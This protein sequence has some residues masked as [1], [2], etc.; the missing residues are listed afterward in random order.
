MYLLGFATE[1]RQTP[2][3]RDPTYLPHDLS[4]SP[5][6]E[7][8]TPGLTDN[9]S[10]YH[11]RSLPPLTPHLQPGAIT[12]S[13]RCHPTSQP[14]AMEAGF[15]WDSSRSTGVARNLFVQ[16]TAPSS[17]NPFASVGRRGSDGFDDLDLNSHAL[18]LNTNVSFTYLLG[19]S[20]M[21]HVLQDDVVHDVGGRGGMERGAAPVQGGGRGGRAPGRPP[22][23]S[24]VMPYRAPR[25]MVN[26]HN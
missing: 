2:P 19:S 12:L 20:P 24:S 14:T 18:D 3:G 4:R 11:R 1:S 16:H 7:P 9:S 5:D 21:I 8:L 13:V 6:A 25:Q 23:P 15:P 26:S 17:S 10:T 22:I